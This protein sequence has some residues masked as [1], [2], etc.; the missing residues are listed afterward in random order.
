MLGGGKMN[1]TFSG[2]FAVENHLKFMIK[3]NT[4]SPYKSTPSKLLPKPLHSVFGDFPK[5]HMPMKATIT[6]PKPV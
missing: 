3:K 4:R 1:A 5:T 2:S 6:A